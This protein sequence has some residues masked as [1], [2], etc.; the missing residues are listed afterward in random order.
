MQQDHWVTTQSSYKCC[1]VPNVYSSAFNRY[2]QTNTYQCFE[3]FQLK[4]AVWEPRSLKHVVRYKKKRYGIN[5][6]LKGYQKSSKCQYLKLSSSRGTSGSW[7]SSKTLWGASENQYGTNQTPRVYYKFYS[8]GTFEFPD[9]APDLQSL[10]LCFC[11]SWYRQSV[12]LVPY[13]CF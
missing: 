8:H 7:E 5:K 2:Q 13:W 4:G 11:F 10:K 12:L 6:T 3:T 1:T 9:L